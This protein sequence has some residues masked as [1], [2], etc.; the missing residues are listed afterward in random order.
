MPVYGTQSIPAC[1]YPGDSTVVV[2][3][4]LTGAGAMVTGAKSERVALF[5]SQH[6]NP[7][8]FSV[9][10]AF[11]GAPGAFSIQVQTSDTDVDGDYVSEGFGGAN[12]GLINAVNA[13]NAARVEL[14]AKAKFA[15]LLIQT[16]PA[17]A[18]NCTA[19]ITR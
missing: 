12:P 10:V 16:Q 15:R 5:N 6:G 14:L 1:P 7:Q 9:E 4:E 8:Y 13:G 17:N 3:N 2:N 19:K 11:S 18:V